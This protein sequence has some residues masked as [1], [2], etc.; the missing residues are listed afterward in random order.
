LHHSYIKLLFNDSCF[1]IPYILA[2][3]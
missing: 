2:H 1:G 3:N